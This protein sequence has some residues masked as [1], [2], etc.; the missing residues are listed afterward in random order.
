VT[1]FRQGRKAGRTLLGQPCDAAPCLVSFGK[2]RRLALLSEG[3]SAAFCSYGARER[4]MERTA[5][6][7]FRRAC[8]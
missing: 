7:G 3:K 2:E 8:T 1:R 4:P 6:N 5:K